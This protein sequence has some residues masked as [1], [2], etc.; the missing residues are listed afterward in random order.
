SGCEMG[1]GR[2]ECGLDALFN[3]FFRKNSLYSGLKAV[4][5]RFC[6]ISRGEGGGAVATTKQG[7][8]KPIVSEPFLKVRTRLLSDC[9]LGDLLVN[10]LEYVFFLGFINLIMVLF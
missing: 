2:A 7:G 4:F 8:L 1:E 10:A 9:L 6:H 5:G 3:R